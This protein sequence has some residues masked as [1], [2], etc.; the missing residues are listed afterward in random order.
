MDASDGLAIDLSRLVRESG[1]GAM[2]ETD[3]LPI[4]EDA[5]RLA[6][7]RTTAARPWN[8]PW[9]TAR[10]SSCCWPCRPTSP[11]RMLALAAAGV[12]LT[13]IGQYMAEPGLWQRAAAG[14]SGR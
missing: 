9:A 8:M 3:R 5:R 6:D 10:I 1:V 4:H 12:P 7:Q 2:L 13:D 14:P 11:R